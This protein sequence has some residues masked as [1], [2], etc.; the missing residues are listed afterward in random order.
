MGHATALY[1][2]VAGLCGRKGIAYQGCLVFGGARLCERAYAS[3]R[4]CRAERCALGHAAALYF[5]LAGLCW[6]NRA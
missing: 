2:F 6:R 5:F 1:F 3:A 4:L